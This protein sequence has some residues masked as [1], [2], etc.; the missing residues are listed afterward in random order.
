MVDRILSVDDLFDV[1]PQT[2][3]RLARNHGLFVVDRAFGDG[4]TDATAAIQS[5][6]SQ[7]GAAGGGTVL[8]PDGTYIKGA[9][10]VVPSGVTVQGVGWGTVVKNGSG[11]GQHVFAIGQNTERVTIRDL[12]ADGNRLSGATTPFS[13]IFAEGAKNCTFHNLDLQGGLRLYGY[14]HPESGRGECIEWANG[15]DGATISD[16]YVHDTD[17]DGVKVRGAHRAVITNLRAH[18]CSKSAVQFA[19]GLGVF[20]SYSSATGV[21]VTHDTGSPRTSVSPAVTGVTYHDALW[22][23]TVNLIARNVGDGMGSAGGPNVG[24]SVTDAT[25]RFK[26]G[27]RL[28]T[29]PER[30]SNV[31]YGPVDDSAAMTTIMSRVGNRSIILDSRGLVYDNN[32]TATVVESP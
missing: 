17:Y 11:V 12:A 29:L 15:S 31:T 23:S 20:A 2:R 3:N 24:C 28:G 6:L 8:I 21:L 7:A 30:A 19:S 27:G 14:P 4:T 18:N 22:C 5:K 32:G 25:L 1:P 9:A 13:V 16:C 10:L 26:V